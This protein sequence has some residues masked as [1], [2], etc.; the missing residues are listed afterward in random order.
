[1]EN[2]STLW[3]LWNNHDV[4]NAINYEQLIAKDDA[5]P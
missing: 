4:L 5:E 1:M 3:L 2:Q